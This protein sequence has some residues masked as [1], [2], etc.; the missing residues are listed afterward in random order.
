MVLAQGENLIKSWNYA[1][2]KA[3]GMFKKVETHAKIEVTNKRI[4][5]SAQSANAVD[6]QEIP[7]NSVKTLAFSQFSK[8]NLWAIIKIVFFGILSLVLI[9]I[10][11]LIKS[12]KEL[13]Q[14]SFQMVITTEGVMTEAMEIGVSKVVLSKKSG[15]PSNVKI[16]I[17]KDVVHDI[18]E[19]L[20]AVV[21]ENKTVA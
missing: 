2:S 21:V 16:M 18:I 15:K 1:D 4:V 13:N 19:T 5:Y 6:R 12:I 3:G 17:N 10:P 9:G 20:G 8:G 11:G 7:L 14:G